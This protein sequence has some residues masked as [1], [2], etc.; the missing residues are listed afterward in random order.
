M[1]FLNPLFLFG[2]LAAAVPVLLHLIK[3]EHARKIE[4]PTL[5]FLR[6][7]D[8]KTIRYQKLRHLLLL[9]LRI[10]AFLFLAFAFM[11]PYL[12]KA[13]VSAALAGRTATAHVI[14]LDNSMS[15]SYRDRWDRAKTA[16][17]DIVQQSHAGDRFALLEFSDMTE[18]RMQLTS[19]SSTVLAEIKNTQEPGDQPTRYA[20]ALK[21]AEDIARKA[22]T[23]KSMIHLISDFQKSEWT[24]EEREYRL[25]PGIGLQCVDLGS[26]EFSN[27]ALR[28]V[29]AFEEEQSGGLNLRMKA[30]IVEFGRR[31]RENVRIGLKLDGRA[32]SEKTVHVP[33]ASSQEIEFQ[34][35]GVSPGEHTVVLE[36]EDPY[37][38]RD[39]RFYMTLDMRGKTPVVV[40][41]KPEVPGQRPPSFFLA[42]AL[43]VDRLSPYKI[44]AVQ[45]QNLDVSG[46][47]LIWN[48][49]PAG[50]TAIQKRLEDF[51]KH[52][53]GMILVLGNAT[54]ASAFNRSFGTWL[55]IKMAEPLS[56]KRRPEAGPADDFALMTDVRTKH[57]IFLPFSKPHSGTFSSARFYRYSRIT[58]GPGAEVLARFDTGDP[59][60][61]A[62]GIEKG[63]VLIF[64]SSAD[65]TGN[66][67]PLQA[68]YAP[69][70]QQML[71]YLNSSEEPRNWLEIGDVIDP[72]KILSEEA[73]RRSEAE[74]GSAKAIALLDPAKQRLEKS[75]N[76]ESIVAEK[77]GF[78]DVRTIGMN[79]TVAVNTMPAES[80]LTHRSAEEMTAAWMSAPREV[81]SQD[82]NP[83]AEEQ[84]SRQHIW[85]FLLLAALVFLVTEL[86]LS[87]RTVKVASDDARKVSASDS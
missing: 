87:N 28:N 68:V 37:L 20:Q 34:V 52:G 76:S 86:L 61:I 48:D 79:A 12:E 74:P 11:R 10:L 57:P 67:L 1:A 44:K 71:H 59:A 36:T 4:F 54:E 75:A 42:K 25:G 47:L 53:G 29:R 21:V 56:G 13:S 5:M 32:L 55:P 83:T 15:M 30:S 14:V 19:D 31:D 45:P 80:D 22:G 41:E 24:D 51:V 63:Q 69:F 17:E 85:I 73:R 7:I 40:V 33:G 2:A 35:P 26:D 60:L 50:T 78:Y 70:W 6:K 77:A 39:N 27:L 64:T 65:D 23:E 3:R 46:K 8:K 49:L 9:L 81:L 84:D 43:N 82:E 72:R 66:D 38:V 16:A 18:I 58:A 62:V